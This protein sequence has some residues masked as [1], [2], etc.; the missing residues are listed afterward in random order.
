MKKYSIYGVLAVMSLG[1]AACDNYEEPNPTPQTNPQTSILQTSDVVVASKV[2]TEA[3]SLKSL[4]D[5]NSKLLISDMT[6]ENMPEGYSFKAVAQVSADNFASSYECPLIVEQVD[7]TN[8]YNVEVAPDALQGVYFENIS[9]N[10]AEAK[11]ALRYALYT[12]YGKQTARV[13]GPDTFYGPFEFSIVPFPAAKVIENAYYLVGTASDGTVS[14]AVKLQHSD[15]NPYDDPVFSAKFDVT[16]NWEWQVIPESTFAAGKLEGNTVY[17]V[18]ADNQNGLSGKLLAVAD[19]GVAGVL[20]EG[21]PYLLTINMDELTYSFSL[22]FDQLYTPGNSNGWSQTA[23]Q[24]LTTNDYVNYSGY[25]FLNGE[26][27]FSTAPNWDGINYGST[28]VEGQLTN[29]GGAGNLNAATAGLYWLNVNIAN[30]TYKATLCNS[31]G[32]IGDA[33][34]GGW[35]ADTNLTPSAD[36]LVWTGTV[37]LKEGAFKFRANGGWDI[38]LGG[39]MQNLTPGGADIASPGAGTYEIKLDLSKVPYSCTLTKK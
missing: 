11:I 13:G 37:E 16:P 21:N 5:E 14:Q 1:F 31:Y 32:L 9:R 6:V 12:V 7:S 38:N 34:P 8:V 26:F 17:G 10:P 33:T 15:I 25:A 20:S 23:S 29:D 3:Y 39:D 19:G 30:L 2:V 28:G 18:A 24:I 36:F 27:K 35:N 4:N 22:A